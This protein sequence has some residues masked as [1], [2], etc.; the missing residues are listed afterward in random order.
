MVARTSIQ[1]RLI[2]GFENVLLYFGH[3][4]LK[5]HKSIPIDSQAHVC[6]SEHTRVYAPL[7][8]LQHSCTFCHHSPQTQAYS[9]KSVTSPT[10]ALPLTEFG[11][12]VGS[13]AARSATPCTW[14]AG[15]GHRASSR[16]P[17]SAPSQQHQSEY[18]VKN[19]PGQGHA[20][21]HSETERTSNSLSHSRL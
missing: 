8:I 21:N 18:A 14:R 12:Q 17:F 2:R 20:Q 9:P 10:G 1:E 15:R 19:L 13:P 11:R 4:H 6:L 3:A 16:A 7:S 5:I